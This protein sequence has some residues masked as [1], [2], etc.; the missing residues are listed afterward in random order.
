[1]SDS[2]TQEKQF[3]KWFLELEDKFFHFEHNQEELF[4]PALSKLQ[5][6]QPDLVFEIGPEIDGKREFI[7][8]ANGLK[9]GFSSVIEVAKAAPEMDR[10]IVVPFRQRK[11]NLDIEIQ[12]GELTLGVEDIFFT[13]EPSGNKVNI[14]LYIAGVNPKEEQ[15]YH[16]ALLLMDNVIGEY[17]V[18][19]KLDKIEIHQLTEVEDATKLYS[20]K[21]LPTLLDGFFSKKV[22]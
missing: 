16:V 5:D 6:I 12:L 18:E 17:D 4:D 20:L 2:D 9:E 14:D 13:Y 3:W 15:V 8:S 21:E 22:D 11:K 10:W 1:M 19:M 7:I